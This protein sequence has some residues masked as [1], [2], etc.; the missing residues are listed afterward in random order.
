MQL[1][2]AH[3]LLQV[4]LLMPNVHRGARFSLLVLGTAILAQ[5]SASF[6]WQIA[7]PQNANLE[8]SA[9]K[10]DI[11]HVKSVETLSINDFQ[12]LT[13]STWFGVSNKLANNR[14]SSEDVTDNTSLNLALKG[15]IMGDNTRAIIWNGENGQTQILKQGDAVVSGVKVHDITRRKVILDNN[16]KIEALELPVSSLFASN[17]TGSNQAIKLA[18]TPRK[19]AAQYVLLHKRKATL[20]QKV[21]VSQAEVVTALSNIGSLAEQARF[22]KRR[23]G[24]TIEGY[25]ISQLK[26]NSFLSNLS[27]RQG[28]ILLRVNGVHVTNREKLFPMIM[29]LQ[30]ANKAEILLHRSGETIALTVEVSI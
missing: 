20:R 21:R 19:S 24:N 12:A 1:H 27:I 29:E 28:D 18:S 22:I 26:N 14:L 4:C 3:A 30:N 17:K 2:K 23:S 9:I 5:Q 10:A 8:T 16:G 11:Q 6:M 25:K 15:T 13:D 7:L